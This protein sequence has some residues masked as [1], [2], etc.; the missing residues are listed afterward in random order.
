MIFCAFFFVETIVF[1]SPC[2]QGASSHILFA[3]SM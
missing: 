1:G 2:L 3:A